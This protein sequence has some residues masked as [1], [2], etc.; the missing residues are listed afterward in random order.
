VR[1][2]AEGAKSGW[3]GKYFEQL[4]CTVG[5]DGPTMSCLEPRCAPAGK[6]VAKFCAFKSPEGSSTCSSGSSTP[7]CTEVEFDY[8]TTAPVK[9]TL[10]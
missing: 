2:T 8:P 3:S 1:V 5:T 6:Y 4:Q 10:F 7:T 9:A